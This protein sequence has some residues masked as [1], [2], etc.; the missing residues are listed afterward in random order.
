MSDCLIPVRYSFGKKPYSF[1]YQ[2]APQ[3]QELFRLSINNQRYRILAS[4]SPLTYSYHTL[5]IP[6]NRRIQVININD[7][8]N[9]FSILK[10][11]P[12]YTIL[13]SSMGAGAGVNHM[14][15]HL[16][17]GKED[18]PVLRAKRKRILHNLGLEL[19]SVY[20]WPQDT[21]ILRGDVNLIIDIADKFIKRLQRYNI[22]H[23]LFIRAGELWINPRSR[24]QSSIL[25]NKKFGSWE[26]ILG[27]FNA[28]SRGEYL[29]IT[30]PLFYKILH[31]IQIEPEQK[32]LLDHQIFKLIMSKK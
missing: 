32:R 20:N 21:Y 13:Y 26:T 2:L 31:E 11:Y 6:L 7:L 3:E 24:K 16:I 25:P 9:A 17:A 8:K 30:A 22:P 1:N 18:Y 4:N 29:T 19:L 28:C 27:I 15:L 12:E 10:K 14:H 5:L 23:N